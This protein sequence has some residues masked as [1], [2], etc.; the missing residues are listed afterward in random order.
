[1]SAPNPIPK[2]GPATGKPAVKPLTVRPK[3]PVR[4]PPKILPAWKPRPSVQSQVPAAKSSNKQPVLGGLKNV[5]PKKPTIGGKL[6]PQG[7]PT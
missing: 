5:G 6:K 7:Q 3:L 4:P 2:P 1:M